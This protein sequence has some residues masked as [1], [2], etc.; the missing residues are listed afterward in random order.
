MN[1]VEFCVKRPVAVLMAYLAVVLI[2]II[3]LTRLPVELMPNYSLGD[4]SVFVNIRGGMPPQEVENMVAKP[5]EEAVGD[6]THL[7][8]II[9]ISEEGRCRV[10][11]RF[12]PGVN[13]DYAAI[14]VRE[15]MA[16]IKD[17]FPRECERPVIAKFEQSDS[18]VLIVALAGPDYTPEKLRKLVDEGVKDRLMR[19]E[20]VANV[21]VGGGRERKIMVDVDQGAL[22]A[23]NMSMSAIVNALGAGNL[24]LLVGEQSDE[25]KRY[26]LRVTGQFENIDDIK[27][28]VVSSNTSGAVVRLRDVAK[29]EDSYLEASSFARVNNMQVVSLYIQKE[30]SANTIKVCDKVLKELKNIE[31]DLNL[32]SQNIKFVLTYNQAE[33]IKR[34]INSVR[35]SLIFGAILAVLVLFI[36]LRDIK[37]ILVIFITIP[38]SVI[39]AFA[40]MYLSP[41][42]ITLNIMTLSG[43]A[44]GVGM[45][46]DSAVV[47][48]EN[49]I[50]TNQ[51]G[52]PIDRAIIEGAR[53]MML[54]IVASTLTN[55]VVFL[56]I[57]FV[58]KEIRIIYAGFALTV[59]FSLLASLAAAITL[60]PTMYAQLVKK[61]PVQEAIVGGLKGMHVR[62]RRFLKNVLKLRLFVVTLV[63]ALFLGALVI[64][65]FLI[66]KEF[67]GSAQEEDFTVFVE[68]P[69]GAKLDISN[70]AV[71]DLEKILAQNKA[72]KTFSS[73]IE[74]WSS[75]IYV[76]LA[77]AKERTQSTAQIIEK[78]RPAV[79]AV[80]NKY[81]EAFIYFEQPQSVETNELIVE[82][83]GYD[84]DTLSN[85]AVKMISA[86]EKVKGLKDLKIRWRKGRPEWRI[87]VDRER[88]ATFGLTVEDVAQILHSQIRGLRAT[89][90]HTQGKEVE[91][92]SRFDENSRNTLAKLK[93]LPIE[94]KGGTMIYLE[95]IATFQPQMAPG[96]IWRKNKQRMIQISADRG[97]YSF[98]EAA[99][100]MRQA[101]K[102]VEMPKDYFY[103]FGENYW[104]M[105]ENQRQL[106]FAVFIMLVLVFLVLAS[107]FESYSKP[108]IIM[109][110]VPMAVIGAVAFLILF[111]K[112][113]NIGV[114]MGFIIL[115]G[116]VVNNAIVMLDHISQLEK[117][118]RHTRAILRGACDRLRPVLITSITA[119]LG[120][121]PL[122]FDRSEEAA[123]WSPL[124]VTVAGGLISST[125]LTLF[126]LPC[127]YALFNDIK[128]MAGDW[129]KRKP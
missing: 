99:Q 79:K 86:A 5:I 29:I 102:E 3:S 67:I 24:N 95:Q 52:M 89:L 114:L 51:A 53:E 7:R 116:I 97:I 42:T 48:I 8:D 72:V 121:A 73:R 4:I 108:L 125:I 45:L 14:E 105:I 32:N 84:Y 15:K 28:I 27:N 112:A 50:K 9:S 44:L 83:Y 124:A 37:S 43:L 80:E 118:M 68:L 100:K 17:K 22:A 38:V 61:F 10:A 57:A 20:G 16:S 123:L 120:M 75:K 1:I 36:F 35:T 90:Y 49:I 94:L 69:T 98:G 128:A 76:K 70:Q 30:T 11:L 54:A 126:A 127:I 63:V 119:V 47:V 40:M 46:V 19:I 18:P 109:T 106:I 39:A 66:P 129:R 65:I 2:G 107:L 56:P 64:F 87:I 74:P 71:H 62:Y 113:V 58:N 122:I 101:F 6:V 88:A 41:Q 110:T 34:A 23:H 31:G 85:L 91:V 81:K 117:K 21:E 26:L 78:M 104:R 60:V 13:M 77:S 55:V 59:V 82:I 12:E 92:V 111:H 33:A 93:R 25:A 96:K 115:G 103:Q